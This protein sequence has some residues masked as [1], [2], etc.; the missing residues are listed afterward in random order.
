MPWLGHS[1]TAV[2]SIPT[3]SGG[4]REERVKGH[5]ILQR[6]VQARQSRDQD[7]AVKK[8]TRMRNLLQEFF[9]CVGKLCHTTTEIQKN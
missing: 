2:D 3:R 8:I 4:R 5:M 9:K 7:K 6:A 1:C